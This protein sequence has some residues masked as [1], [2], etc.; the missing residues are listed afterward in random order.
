MLQRLNQRLMNNLQFL[1]VN[2]HLTGCSAPIRD[3]ITVHTVT[4]DELVLLQT[5]R[6]LL[7]PADCRAKIIPIL[8]LLVVFLASNLVLSL[9]L[10]QLAPSCCQ[11]VTSVMST[12]L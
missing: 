3:N 2:N 5:G 4:V 11:A 12:N 10:C 8:L 9:Y 1:L 7:E 6:L